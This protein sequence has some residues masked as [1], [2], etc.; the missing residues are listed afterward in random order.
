MYHP[1]DVYAGLLYFVNQRY[2]T[3]TSTN[4]IRWTSGMVSSMN[5]T[6]KRIVTKNLQT[7]RGNDV[8]QIVCNYCVLAKCRCTTKLAKL[9]VNHSIDRKNRVGFPAKEVAVSLILPSDSYKH[10]KPHYQLKKHLPLAVDK[11]CTRC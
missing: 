11:I 9:G 6:A 3:Q 1:R 2:V 10:S 5:A 8:P 7:V 4:V